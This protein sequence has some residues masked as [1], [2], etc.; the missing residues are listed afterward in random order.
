MMRRRLLLGTAAALPAVRVGASTPRQIRLIVPFPPGGTM[1]AQARL[2]QPLLAAQL[3][4]QVIIDNKPG[5]GTVI[6][7]QEAAR[8]PADGSVIL[9]VANSFTIN[10][11]L[12]G[13][14]PYDIFRDFTPIALTSEIPHALVV[15]AAV[16]VPDY[17]TFIDAARARPG[18]LS[19]ASYGTGTSNHLNTELLARRAG[20]EFTHVPYRGMAQWF[21]DLL[22]NRV[23][24]ILANLPEV[25]PPVREGKLRALAVAHD[26]RVP[27]LPDT[28]TLAELGIP[29]TSNSWF[30]IVAPAGIPAATR[31]ALQV[32][33]VGVLGDAV[34]RARLDEMWIAPIGGDGTR[35]GDLLRREFADLCGGDP[36][37]GRDAALTVPRRPVPP[38]A[39]FAPLRSRPSPAGR[40]VPAAAV[41]LRGP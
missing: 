7:T 22:Q 40:P 15:N 8:A 34:L 32:A 23:Q 30:G 28:P 21:P 12:H 31:D 3:G 27:S 24:F 38:T 41:R 39:P 13:N 20:V 26:A 35:L 2:F 6:G 17:A 37:V 18:S 9:M 1:D 10:P 5:G 29:L 11:T 4:A 36:A 16:P 19:Y 25:V 33:F 14:L